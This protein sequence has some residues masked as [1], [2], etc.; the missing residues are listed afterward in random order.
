[1]PLLKL[2]VPHEKAPPHVINAIAA[3]SVVAIRAVQA[4]CATL[5][6]FTPSA[7]SSV[8]SREHGQ[9]DNQPIRFMKKAKHASI[10]TQAIQKPSLSR[11]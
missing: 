1:M 10:S 4:C 8:R 7:L 5:T 2:R 3:V 6:S 11:I 9:A